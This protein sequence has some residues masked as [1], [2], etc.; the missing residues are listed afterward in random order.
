[1]ACA[2]LFFCLSPAA[3]GRQ[4]GIPAFQ[5]MLRNAGASLA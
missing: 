2:V 4:I 1:V 3:S 5:R